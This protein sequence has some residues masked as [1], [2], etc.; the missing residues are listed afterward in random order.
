MKNFN[1]TVR[2]PL[3]NAGRRFAATFGFVA[4]RPKNGRYFLSAHPEHEKSIGAMVEYVSKSRREKLSKNDVFNMGKTSDVFLKVTPC[5][6][7]HGIDE[8]TL[9]PSGEPI[10]EYPVYTGIDPWHASFSQQRWNRGDKRLLDEF[11]LY[12]DSNKDYTG[13]N[14]VRDELFRL[15]VLNEVLLSTLPIRKREGLVH[16]PINLFPDPVVVKE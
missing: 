16:A 13:L 15:G 12:P 9:E 3:V 10:V 4:E 7:V 1:K 5:V 14:Q 2:Q 6:A 8:I 11:K